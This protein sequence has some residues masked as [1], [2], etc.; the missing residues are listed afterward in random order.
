MR[1]RARLACALSGGEEAV[2][3]AGAEDSSSSSRASEERL[4]AAASIK[5]LTLEQ[6]AALDAVED[7]AVIAFH[8]GAVLHVLYSSY[9]C[10]VL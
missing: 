7:V 5:N 6:S 2:G 10:A 1:L 9:P 8:A 4:K 3:E